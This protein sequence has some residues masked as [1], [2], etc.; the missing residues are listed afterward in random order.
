MIAE[1]AIASCGPVPM[2]PR[3]VQCCSGPSDEGEWE[4]STSGELTSGKLSGCQ[5]G[6]C[7]A[8]S[9]EVVRLSVWKLSGRRCGSHQAVGVEV[10]GF[11]CNPWGWYC[12]GN[13]TDLRRKLH[14][15]LAKGNPKRTF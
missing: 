7:Q 6:S 3:L 10:I 12:K 8:V 9:V 11:G 2:R 14:L 1:G 4:L 15:S 13:L 5:C